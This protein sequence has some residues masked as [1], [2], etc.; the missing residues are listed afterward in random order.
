MAWIYHESNNANSMTR[1]EMENNARELYSQLSGYGWTLNAI[2]GVLGNFQ[3]ESYINP[4]QWQIGFPIG[5]NSGGLGLGQWTPPSHWR[6]WANL[7]GHDLYSGYWQTYYLDMNNV[8]YNGKYWGS[9]WNNNPAPG[10]TW[11][12]FKTSTDT[13]EETANAFFQQWEQPGDAT[14]PQRMQYA[15]EWYNYLSG[16]EPGKTK[17][18]IWLLYKWGIQWRLNF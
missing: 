13:P 1:D 10:W 14:S 18:P 12:Y 3:Y 5:G 4:A 8:Y 16:I 15:R 9:Q 6:D 17:L 2:A 11:D 7:E